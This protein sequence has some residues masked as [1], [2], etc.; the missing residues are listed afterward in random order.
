MHTPSP[1]RFEPRFSRLPAELRLKIWAANVPGP[2]IVTIRCSSTSSPTP[3]STCQSHG[4]DATPCF[5]SSAPIPANLH[6]CR[7]SRWEA[8]R[9]YRLLFGTCGETG[10]IFLDTMGDILYFGARD[11]DA[12]SELQLYNFM[13]LVPFEDMA[14]LRYIA[15]NEML[16]PGGRTLV[17]GA[18]VGAA[19]CT[20]ED[21]MYHISMLFPFLK[22]LFIICGDKNPVYSSD[23]VLAEPSAPNR[24]IE[25]RVDAAIRSIQ[26]KQVGWTPPQWAV[27]VIASSPTRPQYT[28]SLLG[29][30]KGNSRYEASSMADFAK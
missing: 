3:S 22:Q 23:S 20:V 11:G 7:E 10:R 26:R 13:T 24:L 17:D 8:M 16:I 18:S 14:C 5:T 4:K 30:Q 29:W 9:R 19:E 28:E 2:R 27:R 25:R 12:A 6:A 21:V 1:R 15:I